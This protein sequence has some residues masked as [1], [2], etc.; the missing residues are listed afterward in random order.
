MSGTVPGSPHSL[1]SRRSVSVSQDIKEEDENIALLLD[2]TDYSS[3]DDLPVA[4]VV[5][6]IHKDTQKLHFPDEPW[7]TL[8]AA[9]FLA[10]SMI[11]TTIALIITNQR[12]PDT[13]PL[14]DIVLD[15]VEY[16]EIGLKISEKIMIST[17]V[18][19]VLVILAHTHRMII[20]R[21]V[22]FLLG[23]MYYYRAVTMQL[24][25]LP[26]PDTNWSCPKY[27]GSL[28]TGVVF[29]K[30]VEITTGGGISLGDEQPFCGDYIF[31]GHTMMLVMGYLVVR[32][33][34]PR[35]FFILHWLS[36]GMSVTGVVMLLLG[37]GHYSVDVVLA[38]YITTRLW[39]VYHSVANNK[40]VRAMGR[41]NFL[42]KLWWWRIFTFWERKVP[43]P[44]PEKYSLPL[45]RA[46]RERIWSCRERNSQRWCCCCCRRNVENI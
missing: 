28:D 36:L 18:L 33:Y 5:L 11:T 39:W 1:L 30:V 40:A 4:D 27:N 24:T 42:G 32:D 12:V 14:P 37:R 2:N 8:L 43:G 21:R 19:A 34:S 25:V 38:Y 3:E 13:P 45:P 29:A 16:L 15:Y 35:R 41:H 44:V 26:K 20:F 10:S 22:F 9:L 17:I 6:N 46:W 23:L 7:K 31:S